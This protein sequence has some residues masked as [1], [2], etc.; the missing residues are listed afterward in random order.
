MRGA[1]HGSWE[2]EIWD[3]RLFDPLVPKLLLFTV[4]QNKTLPNWTKLQF[5][6]EVEKR[7][8]NPNSLL[9]QTQ[10]P[11]L[12]GLLFHRIPEGVWTWCSERGSV[13]SAVVKSLEIRPTDTM[14]QRSAIAKM[15]SPKVQPPL[16]AN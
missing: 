6:T 9:P 7:L 3:K 10:E 8:G 1:G 4:A 5:R 12:P 11:R 13:R 15:L 14:P 2:R 16:V